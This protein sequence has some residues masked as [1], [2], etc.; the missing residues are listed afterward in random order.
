MNNIVDTLLFATKNFSQ[1]RY[2]SMIL[3]L[4]TVQFTVHWTAA[5]LRIRSKRRVDWGRVSV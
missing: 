2:Y 3:R 4:Y 1:S 5:K